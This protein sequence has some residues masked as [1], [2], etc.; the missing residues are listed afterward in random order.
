MEFPIQDKTAKALLTG[1]KECNSY[2]FLMQKKIENLFSIMLKIKD[3][4][5]K[6]INNNLPYSNMIHLDYCLQEIFYIE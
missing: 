5:T 4:I 2:D 6:L 3:R 1:L